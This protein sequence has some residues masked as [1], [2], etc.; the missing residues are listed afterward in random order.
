MRLAFAC[1]DCARAEASDACARST[2]A[3]A[4]S[5]SI[6]SRNW[7]RATIWPSRT[8]RRTMRPVTSAL[9]ST[10]VCGRIWPLAVTDATRSRRCTGSMRTATALLLRLAAVSPRIRA[11]ATTV[12]PVMDHFTRLLIFVPRVSG[13]V[14]GIV[15]LAE[16]PADRVLERREGPVVLVD[17]VDAGDLRLLV[18]RVRGGD[19]EEG[20]H[21]DAVALLG[22]GEL[23]ARAG[24]VL[25]LERHRPRRRHEGEIGLRDVGRRLKLAGP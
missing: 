10:L 25:L 22:E 8:A 9:R 13:R 19:V 5:G 14:A 16:R 7:P 24:G 2:A 20:R 12:A 4:C 15:G 11:M 18:R 17:G 6:W 21:A 3:R 23:L 1:A